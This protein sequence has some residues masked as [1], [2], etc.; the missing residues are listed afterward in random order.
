[1]MCGKIASGKSTLAAQLAAEPATVLVSEDPWLAT[2]FGDEMT[3]IEDYVGCSA[4]LRQV[5][6]PHAS[7]VLRSGVSVVL[8][9][10]ANTVESRQWMRSIFEDAQAAHQLHWLDVPD[11]DCLAR[12]HARNATSAHPFSVTQ[13]EFARVTRHFA[14]PAPQEGF[15]IVLHKK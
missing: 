11:E 9:F 14:A 15:N 10:H 4:K 3:S 5:I 1:M 13:D 2:L 12:L 7:Q 6:G 8:D